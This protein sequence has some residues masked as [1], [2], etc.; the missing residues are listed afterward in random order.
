MVHS[1]IHLSFSLSAESRCAQGK[2]I[3]C[4]NLSLP[5]GD[6]PIGIDANRDPWQGFKARWACPWHLAKT[7]ERIEIR[8]VRGADEPTTSR[9]VI[10]RHT[11]MGTGLFAGDEI[12][13]A[14]ME[15]QTC[16]SIG[17]ISE[18]GRAISSHVGVTDYRTRV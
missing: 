11:C 2:S 4:E 8:T 17:G 5:G 15:E 1:F 12:P 7:I 13:I 14:K 3:R 6:G 16:L 18:T 9:I 10:D